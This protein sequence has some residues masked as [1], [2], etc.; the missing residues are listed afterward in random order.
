MAFSS[1][2]DGVKTLCRGLGVSEH[3]P[4]LEKA[5][6][7]EMGGWDGQ[8]RI[9]ALD[10]FSLVVEVKSSPAMQEITLR[11]RELVRRLNRHFA[12]P[13]LRDVTVR[14]MPDGD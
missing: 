11:R 3:L 2:Q 9:A 8:A 7:A 13:F 14:M 12:A 4:V 1:I 5:W 10:K 6:Q